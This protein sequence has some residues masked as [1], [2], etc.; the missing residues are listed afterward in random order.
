MAHQ[1]SADISVFTNWRK[2]LW[3]Y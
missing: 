1:L 3:S 2:S